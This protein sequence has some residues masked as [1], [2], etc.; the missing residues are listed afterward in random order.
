[1]GGGEAG[2]FQLVKYNI[3]KNVETNLAKSISLRLKGL[4]SFNSFRGLYFCLGGLK[5]PPKRMPDYVTGDGAA[6]HV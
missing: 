4:M 2:L 3:K 6:E 1:L 5:P